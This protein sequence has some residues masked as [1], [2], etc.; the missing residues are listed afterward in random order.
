MK[1]R[2]TITPVHHR[3]RSFGLSQS[4]DRQTLLFQLNPDSKEVFTLADLHKA[5]AVLHSTTIK[6]SPNLNYFNVY[7][8][9]GNNS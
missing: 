7:I 8:E 6:I 9:E 1:T 2:R 5:I 4:V 3:R